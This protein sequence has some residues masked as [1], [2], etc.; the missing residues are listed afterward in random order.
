MTHMGSSGGEVHFRIVLFR[1]E[2]LLHLSH[3]V[4]CERDSE[5]EQT[6]F[7]MRGRTSNWLE[8]V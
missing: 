7:P 1:E 8:N 2:I 5:G 6:S 3:Q 4:G